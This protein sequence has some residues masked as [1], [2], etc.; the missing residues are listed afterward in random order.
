[1]MARM[2]LVV[3]TLEWQRVLTD[4]GRLSEL[5]VNSENGVLVDQEGFPISLYLI[6]RKPEDT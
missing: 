1:M 6:Q 3:Y 2:W 5:R 4:Q